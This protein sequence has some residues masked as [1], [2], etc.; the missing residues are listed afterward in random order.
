MKNLSKF[1]KII[2]LEKNGFFVNKGE[3]LNNIYWS[4]KVFKDGSSEAFLDI[5]QD[6]LT[7]KKSIIHLNN[8][9]KYCSDKKIYDISVIINNPNIKTFSNNIHNMQNQFFSNEFFYFRN[10]SLK[11]DNNYIHLINKT[12]KMNDN[13]IKKYKNNN[14][15]YGQ[16]DIKLFS[17][18][19]DNKNYDI[20]KINNLLNFD[21]NI[22]MN[23]N[24]QLPI[25]DSTKNILFKRNYIER[26]S[27][28]DSKKIISKLFDF[29]KKLEMNYSSKELNVIIPFYVKNIFIK[30]DKINLFDLQ[31]DLYKVR[32]NLLFNFNIYLNNKKI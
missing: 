9:L 28:S 27:C 13:I 16:R 29:Q 30:N 18:N 1:N 3:Y 20:D 22:I 25:I 31:N 17:C 15:I 26:I 7:T 21:K 6:T 8:W 2:Q 10:M 14:T 5:N 19:I 24:V 4:E 11:Y 32:K 23:Y 12:N